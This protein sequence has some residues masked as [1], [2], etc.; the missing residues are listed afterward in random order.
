MTSYSVAKSRIIK[1]H[2]TLTRWLTFFMGGV[3][4]E[5]RDGIKVFRPVLSG[6]KMFLS[7]FRVRYENCLDNDAQKLFFFLKPF[8]FVHHRTS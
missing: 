2:S 5:Y 8:I 7:Y 4:S 3:G 1:Y 6:C